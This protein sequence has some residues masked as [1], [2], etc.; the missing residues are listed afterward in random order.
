MQA[1]GVPGDSVVIVI[2]AKLRVQPLAEC[3]LPV[4]PVLLAPRGE[5]LQGALEFLAGHPP[6]AVRFPLAALAPPKR[7]PRNSKRVLPTWPCRLNSMSRVL[8]PDRASPHFPRRCPSTLSKRSASAWSS[9]AH[10]KSNVSVHTR[11]LRP[12]QGRRHLA[13]A[14]SPLWPA[15]CSERVGTQEWPDFGAPYPTCT[16]LCQRF[17]VSVTEARA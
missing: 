3:W 1:G 7:K 11:G 10:T 12:R 4:V 5:A 8:A 14:V 13:L 16:F 6:L 9:N 17:T 2:P 15:A